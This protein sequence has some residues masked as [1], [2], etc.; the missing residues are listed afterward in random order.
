MCAFLEGERPLYLQDDD[1]QASTHKQRDEAADEPA[2]PENTIVQAHDPH[3]LLQPSLLF[4][5]NALDD[6]SNRVNPGQ[7]H[8]E[9]HGPA[10]HPKETGDTD[11][12]H[13]KKLLHIRGKTTFG[14]PREG[15]LD[16]QMTKC[17]ISSR[18]R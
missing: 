8:E 14:S 9:G 2:K 17:F 1:Q 7:G 13:G 3:G 5:Y 10:H 11:E 15:P 12:K 18:Q 16:S 6:H 4:I